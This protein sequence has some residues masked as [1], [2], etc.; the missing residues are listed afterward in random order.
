MFF[1]NILWFFFIFNKFKICDSSIEEYNLRRDL[2]HNYEKDSRPIYDINKPVDVDM[3]LAI[4]TLEQFNQ[5]TETIK[6][7]IWFRMN[8]INEYMYWYNNSNYTMTSIDVNPTDIWTPDIE[9]INAAS[10]PEIYTLK[11]GL[12]LYSNG[13]CMWSRPGIFMFSCPLDLH[14]FPF[15]IQSCSMTFASWIFSNQ[16][17]NL[18]PYN[19]KEKAVDILN[20]FSHSEWNIKN[21]EYETFYINM[22]NNEKK[23]AIRYTI[24]LE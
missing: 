14:N 5:K 16:Y 10:L 15:D 6:L 22:E 20:D 23:S 11:G 3:G 19:N 13:E 17:L 18:K 8:W 4:Q 9:L 21:V 1:K 24:T 12:M 7:N 2:F